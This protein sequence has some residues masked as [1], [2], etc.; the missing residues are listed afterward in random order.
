MN[1]PDELVVVARDDRQLRLALLSVTLAPGVRAGETLEPRPLR[2]DNDTDA[3]REQHDPGPGHSSIVPPRG[4]LYRPA[5]QISIGRSAS[6]TPPSGVT[7]HV[8]CM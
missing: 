2:G 4:T 8:S 7:S 5:T 3:D 6:D 1:T